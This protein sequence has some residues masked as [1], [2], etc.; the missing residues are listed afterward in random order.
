MTSRDRSAG[1]I[2]YGV[3]AAGLEIYSQWPYSEVSEA[4]ICK[5]A[6]IT[7]AALRHHFGGKLGLFMSVF[8]SL[9]QGVF[10]RIA[11]AVGQHENP[12]DSVGEGIAALWDECAR[13]AYQTVVL[14]EGPAALGW[15]RWLE[16]DN[17]HYSE[18]L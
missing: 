16:L 15:E 2:Q 10:T 1:S 6:G 11:V 3:L 18:L 17:A 12:W 13:P 5:H 8:E 14:R 7:P 4:K 9:Q